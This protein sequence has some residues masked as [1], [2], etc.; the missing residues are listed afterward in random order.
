M[1]A[2]W[3]RDRLTRTSST[4]A[5]TQTSW[6]LCSGVSDHKSV[7]HQ[8]ALRKLIGG[9][10]GLLPRRPKRSKVKEDRDLG[11]VAASLF[12]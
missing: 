4:C 5:P 3:N 7:E 8:I 11:L 2:W 1:H 9:D 10:G 12:S 6:R